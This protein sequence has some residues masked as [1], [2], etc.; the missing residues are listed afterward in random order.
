MSTYRLTPAAQRDLS[1]IWDY[2]REQWGENQ[3]ETY[4]LEIRNA[5]ENGQGHGFPFE[6]GGRGARRKKTRD[7][8]TAYAAHAVPDPLN[9]NLVYGGKITRYDRRTGQVINI[10]PKPVRPAD[11]RALRTAPVV[12]LSPCT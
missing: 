7:H 4:I 9:A 6:R 8:A 10:F 5:I 3:A 11:M 2:T 1:S 12:L